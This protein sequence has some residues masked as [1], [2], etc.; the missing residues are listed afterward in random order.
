MLDEAEYPR[1]T[2]LCPRRTT[3]ALTSWMSRKS[4]GRAGNLH[5]FLHNLLREAPKMDGWAMMLETKKSENG[6]GK[7]PQE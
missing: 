4:L 6:A 2:T 1:K 7:G 5:K 3:G